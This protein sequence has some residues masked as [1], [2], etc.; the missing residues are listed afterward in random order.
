MNACLVCESSTKCDLCDKDR[1]AIP[2]GS[3]PNVNSCKNENS[4]GNGLGFADVFKSLCGTCPY[5]GCKACDLSDPDAGCTECDSTGF[6]AIDYSVSDYIQSGDPNYQKKACVDQTLTVDG[7]FK[8]TTNYFKK[9]STNCKVCSDST[10]CTQCEHPSGPTTPIYHISST[11]PHRC[12]QCVQSNHEYFT[13]ANPKACVACP[14]SQRLMKGGLISSDCSPCLTSDSKYIDSDGYG[15]HC[16]SECSEC[17]DGLKCTKCK[18]QEENLQLDGSCSQGCPINHKAD[19]NRICQKISCSVIDCLE[20]SDNNVCYSCKAGYTLNPTTHTCSLQ[21]VQQSLPSTTPSTTPT[22]TETP[23]EKLTLNY[24]LVQD[25]DP[26]HQ[27]GYLFKINIKQENV[28]AEQNREINQLFPKIDAKNLHLVLSNYESKYNYPVPKADIEIKTDDSNDLYLFINYKL[29]NELTKESEFSNLLQISH[30]QILLNLDEEN[31]QNYKYEYY[32]NETNSVYQ[33]EDYVKSQKEQKLSKQ[34][35]TISEQAVTL[36]TSTRVASVGVVVVFSAL[37]VDPSGEAIKFNQFLDLV[38][39]FKYFGFWFGAKLNAFIDNLSGHNQQQQ[40][41][42]PRNS[43]RRR[44]LFNDFGGL[45]QKSQFHRYKMEKYRIPLKFEGAILFKAALYLVLWPLKLIR[46]LIFSAMKNNPKSKF[47]KLKIHLVVY[48]R[49]IHFAAL[50]VVLMDLTFN[51]TRIIFHREND[52]EGILSKGIAYV[53]LG[54]FTID[55]FEIF[56]VAIAGNYPRKHADQQ[57]RDK[58]VNQSSIRPLNGRNTK[59]RMAEERE[60]RQTGAERHPFKMN[61]PQRRLTKMIYSHNRRRLGMKLRTK[62]NNRKDK[63]MDSEF[64]TNP[65]TSIAQQNTNSSKTPKIDKN[66]QEQQSK[67]IKKK[68][69]K[70][71]DIKKT[72]E[73][74]SSDKTIEVVLFVILKPLVEVGG[75]GKPASMTRLKES[76]FEGRGLDDQGSSFEQSFGTGQNA[77]E[78]FKKSSVRKTGERYDEV[79]NDFFFDKRGNALKHES[80]EHPSGL[81]LNLM[82]LHSW[83]GMVTLATYQVLVPSLP[84]LPQLLIPLMMI[85]ELANITLIYFLYFGSHRFINCFTLTAKTSRFVFIEGFLIFS[86]ILCIESN[87]KRK[88]LNE[89][90]QTYAVLFNGLGLLSEYIAFAIKITLIIYKKIKNFCDGVKAEPYIYY[91]EEGIGSEDS[92][93]LDYDRGVLDLKSQ[94]YGSSLQRHL[95]NSSNKKQKPNIQKMLRKN[96]Q[97]KNGNKD[98]E[99]RILAQKKQTKTQKKRSTGSLMFNMNPSRKSGLEKRSEI[100]IFSQKS[101]HSED[102]EKNEKNSQE[103]NLPKNRNSPIREANANKRTLIQEPRGVGIYRNSTIFSIKSKGS[104]IK[105]AAQKN[106]NKNT[107]EEHLDFFAE[108]EKVANAKNPNS[109]S[110]SIEFS[111]KSED[112]E[113]KT[114]KGVKKSRNKGEDR[115]SKFGRRELGS[116][117]LTLNLRYY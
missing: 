3:D 41:E 95:R 54:L 73:Y 17:T 63:T 26:Y 68:K 67:L 28:T 47:S 59:E 25:Y 103:W 14:T 115:G 24:V 99:K 23:K 52:F 46:I 32:L 77:N 53:C 4:C 45:N 79:G 44:V 65:L 91:R 2:P 60:S 55:L 33:I 107:K 11:T 22:S 58:V 7:Y 78:S 69:K 85:I 50:G 102:E 90:I 38:K 113:K 30:R 111:P 1:L 106:P 42:S 110:D 31:D 96:K 94:I 82:K 51:S 62:K 36:T 56:M 89:H 70:L 40:Q 92:D 108:L 84:L 71:V 27:N 117:K 6:K 20:C 88:P 75:L 80:Q 57:K 10:T 74:N 29:E 87:N 104:F 97:P 37:S 83:F 76:H 100:Q 112:P 66:R 114:G 72:I 12:T 5:E 35:E 9:C 13:E 64:T 15:N 19:P 98:G 61:P 21:I 105:K 86:L 43:Q 93:F 116:R 8:D 81:A 34:L 18:N 16:R 48:M 101:K 109:N 49:K 39:L